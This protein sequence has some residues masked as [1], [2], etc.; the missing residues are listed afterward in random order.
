MSVTKEVDLDFEVV[1][2]GPDWLFV[3]LNPSL[4]QMD[5]VA[6]RLW[7]LMTQQ[8]VHRIVLEMDEVRFLPSLLIGQLIML[9]KRVLEHDGAMRLCGL[10]PSCIDA[11]KICRLDHAL[12]NFDC[13]EDAVHGYHHSKPK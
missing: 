12:P 3:R 8:F 1:D 11:I 13:R 5:D 6:D 7:T 2:R 4:N 10:S 9:Q